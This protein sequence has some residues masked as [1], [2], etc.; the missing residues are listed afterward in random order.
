MS[1][2]EITDLLEKGIAPN[3]DESNSPTV[4]PSVSVPLTPA[5]EVAPTPEPVAVPTT[6]SVPTV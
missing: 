2:Q 1:G 4:G 5:E 3:R 6:T